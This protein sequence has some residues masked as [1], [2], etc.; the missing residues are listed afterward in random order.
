MHEWRGLPLQDTRHS[1]A[2]LQRCEQAKMVVLYLD[3]METAFDLEERK[4]KSACVKGDVAQKEIGQG[5]ERRNIT[6]VRG[7]KSFLF[8]S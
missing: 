2:V 4:R 7:E 8:V 5:S 3:K 1:A 6:S